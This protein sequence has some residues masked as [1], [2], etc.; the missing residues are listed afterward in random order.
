MAEDSSRKELVVDFQPL[1]M[2]KK[3]VGILKEPS[4]FFSSSSCADKK[5]IK[6][7]KVSFDILKS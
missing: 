2:R 7:K 4:E 5:F 3:S 6:K 1:N